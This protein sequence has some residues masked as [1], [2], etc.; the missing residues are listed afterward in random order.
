MIETRH[1]G[2]DNFS[3]HQKINKQKR[4]LKITKQTEMIKNSLRISNFL[5]DY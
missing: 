1:K 4:Y 5:N 2:T 3:N